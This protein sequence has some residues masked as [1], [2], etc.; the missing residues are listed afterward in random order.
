MASIHVDEA[1]LNALKNAFQLSFREFVNLIIDKQNNIYDPREFVHHQNM[2]LPLTDYYCHSSHN[3]YLTGNQITSESSVEMYSYVLKN[4]CRFLDLDTFDG[5]EGDKAEPII[6][7]WHF[8]VGDISFK[9]ALIVIKEH[10]SVSVYYI[11][12]EL[13]GLI[14][15]LEL[16]IDL[17][18]N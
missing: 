7:H 11:L 1:A 16:S 12:N 10:D 14:G 6:T 2:N 9:D 13:L 8:P 18:Y 17:P 5:R 15:A 4:G 3:T